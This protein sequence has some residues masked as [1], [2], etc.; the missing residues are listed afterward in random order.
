MIIDTEEHPDEEVHRARILS[1][2]ASVP[3]KWACR[4]VYQPRSSPN[5]MLLGFL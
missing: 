3:M 4:H 5:P 2:G 1:T